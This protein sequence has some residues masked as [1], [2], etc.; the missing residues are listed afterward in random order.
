MDLLK[1]MKKKAERICIRNNNRSICYQE[2]YE[3]TKNNQE[4]IRAYTESNKKQGQ[5]VMFTDITLGWKLIP[6]YLACLAEKV[7]IIPIDLINSPNQTKK[8]LT[9]HL[10]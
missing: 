7:T 3:T 10:G 5:P 1:L 6:L 8:Y 2:I 4:L 9:Q